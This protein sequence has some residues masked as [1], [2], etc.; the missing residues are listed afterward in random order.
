MILIEHIVQNAANRYIGIT[1][2]SL[3]ELAEDLQARVSIRTTHEPLQPD[4]PDTHTPHWEKINILRDFAA[5]DTYDR[6]IFLDA[7]IIASPICSQVLRGEL[8]ELFSG[9]A[10][11]E[12]TQALQIQ[13]M[14]NYHHWCSQFYPKHTPR[15]HY[16]NS[17][18]MFVALEYARRW[19]AQMPE[20]YVSGIWEQHYLNITAPEDGLKWLSQDYNW[21]LK[22]TEPRPPDST[23]FAH[24]FGAP[25]KRGSLWA[26]AQY[27]HSQ[28]FTRE[29]RHHG[30]AGI[31]A[32]FPSYTVQVPTAGQHEV[33]IDCSRPDD[34]FGRIHMQ[35]NTADI[36]DRTVIAEW[37]R[38]EDIERPMRLMVDFPTAGNYTFTFEYVSGSQ[39]FDVMAVAIGWFEIFSRYL[40]S[41]IKDPNAVILQFG[42]YIGESWNDPLYRALVDGNF[43]GEFHSLEPHPE[44]YPVLEACY[45]KHDFATTHQLAISNVTGKG[46]F[47]TLKEDP[48]PHGFPEWCRQLSSLRED[49]YIGQWHH[50]EAKAQGIKGNLWDLMTT[51]EVPTISYQDFVRENGLTRVDY[52]S[53]DIEGHEPEVLEDIIA[54][55]VHPRFIAFE[56]VHIRK[57]EETITKLVKAGYRVRDQLD[58]DMIVEKMS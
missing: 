7:D 48:V 22:T 49:R 41:V 50:V 4:R 47:Q 28:R 34:S 33:I 32:N 12:D 21:C 45:A 20:D 31:C 55:D 53:M 35:E 18:I 1:M 10:I 17:G 29:D 43:Q 9:L 13:I 30:Q 23:I 16:F 37:G 57:L 5:Q 27:W 3:L 46:K 25:D 36:L 39:Q 38:P 52:I 42:G 58:M 24:A 51:I 26:M 8:E 40:R 14:S 54:S 6:L 56:F 44:Y 19:V 2:P 15:D 11:V